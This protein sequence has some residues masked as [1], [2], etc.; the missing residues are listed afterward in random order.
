M[1]RTLIPL[2]VLL[3]RNKI[4]RDRRNFAR[5]ELATERKP[6]ARNILL[7]TSIRNVQRRIH[8][9]YSD[10]TQHLPSAAARSRWIHKVTAHG[11]YAASADVYNVLSRYQRSRNKARRKLPRHE[12]RLTKREEKREEGRGR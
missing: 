10:C 8:W 7:D 9:L 5:R 4:M 6:R 3:Q 12:R 11:L 2:A 1:Q